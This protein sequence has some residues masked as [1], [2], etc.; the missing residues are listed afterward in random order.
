MKL[1]AE[2]VWPLILDFVKMY[3]GKEELKAFKKHFSVEVDES[4]DPL[5]KAGGMKAILQSFFKSNKKVYKAFVTAKK[6]KAAKDS[7]SESEEEVP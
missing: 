7:D 5:V 4:V 1:T 3:L 6:A 2:D